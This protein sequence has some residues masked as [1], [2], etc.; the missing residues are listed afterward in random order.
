MTLLSKTKEIITDEKKI[1]N[2]FNNHYI[3]I[4]EISPLLIST[5]FI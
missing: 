5:I 3:N 1:A 4:V 2:L